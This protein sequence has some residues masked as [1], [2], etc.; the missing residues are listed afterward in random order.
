[1][2]NVTIRMVII[3][4]ALI[5]CVCLVGAI[6]IACQGREVPPFLASVTGA[7]LG[8]LVG[9]LATPKIDRPSQP[10]VPMVPS[11]WQQPKIPTP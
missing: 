11:Q 5:C 8:S 10:P 6:V 3:A 4:L 9:I 2:D 1:M 7:A